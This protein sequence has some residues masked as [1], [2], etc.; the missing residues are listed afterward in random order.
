MLSGSKKKEEEE[1]VEEEEEKKFPPK[2]S[3]FTLVRKYVAHG[4][5]AL[6]GTEM[7]PGK[8]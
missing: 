8:H 3:S 2:W 6:F 5:K 7:M 4:G 1:E